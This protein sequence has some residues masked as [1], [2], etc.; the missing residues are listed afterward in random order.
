MI[1]ALFLIL[2]PLQLKLHVESI[3]V[4]TF[5]IGRREYL[6]ICG[7]DGGQQRVKVIAAG[8]AV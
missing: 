1:G 6:R 5:R 4:W 2:G 3:M 8:T 7:K